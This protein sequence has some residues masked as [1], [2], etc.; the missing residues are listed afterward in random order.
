MGKRIKRI[1]MTLCIFLVAGLGIYEPVFSAQ[2]N[3]S[4][5]I[6]N[7]IHDHD[8]NGTAKVS[9]SY[10]VSN[11]DGTFTRV[12]NYGD[13][14]LV[15]TY[16]SAFKCIKQTT[17]PFEL[18]IFGGFY[19]GLKYNYFVFGQPNYN[20]DVHAEC[21]R[22]VKYSKDWKRIWQY[23][24][25]DCNVSVPFYGA[26]TDFCEV[27]DNLYIRCGHLGYSDQYGYRHQ[28]PLTISVRQDIQ[29]INDVQGTILGEDWGSIENI[30]AT[31]ID[32]TSGVLTAVDH[33]FT[34]P[35][36]AVV[37]AYYNHAG[38][39]SFESKCR[40]VKGLGSKIAINGNSPEF[41][42]GGYEV[43]AQYFLVAGTSGIADGSASNKNVVIM[44]VPRNSF[45][46]SDV[47][48]TYLTGFAGDAYTCTNPYIVNVSP[49]KY[50]VLWEE[51]YGY[52]DL[53]QVY[54]VYID[55]SGNRLSDVEYIDGCLS[56]CQP[57]FHKGK[58]IWYTTD[59][60]ANR[61]YSIDIN[62]K[63]K[64]SSTGTTTYTNK[65]A[66]YKG[67]DFSKVYDYTYYC[68]HYP[69]IRVLYGNNPAGAIEHFVTKGMA[70][71]RQAND[72]FNVYKYKTNYE[73]L[74]KLYGEDLKQ[75]YVHFVLYGSN[76][77]RNGRTYN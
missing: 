7:N 32:A 19:S 71:G 25:G 16:N 46:D 67:V 52:S 34:S 51:K 43:S 66:V 59:G 56:D 33:S 72:N 58:I 8:Y 6:S 35:Y 47:K 1:I 10:L 42:I 68:A 77:G 26:N 38:V 30:G 65:D 70:E 39:T 45:T 31:F 44:S 40:T 29:S 41:T 5:I 54:Y 60:A 4:N 3:G 18:S 64:S 17:V 75:Y 55:G 69:D 22:V 27:G 37:S 24:I 74:R 28:G 61:L 53:G 20:N 50:C 21:I 14:I 48:L 73:D 36:S 63:S 15:E 9:N 62:T 11:A 49:E 57:I 23:N 2:Y 13:V 76:E 12:E